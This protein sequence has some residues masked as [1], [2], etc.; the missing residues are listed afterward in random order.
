MC[1]VLLAAEVA[2]EMVMQSLLKDWSFICFNG[3]LGFYLS[4]N[5]RSL[6]ANILY[7]D[8]T[9]FRYIQHQKNLNAI[10]VKECKVKLFITLNW[11]MQHRP[12]FQICLQ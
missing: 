4:P 8:E 9:D 2:Y 12:E 3:F 10:Y 11:T 1:I 7:C 5:C 6:Y